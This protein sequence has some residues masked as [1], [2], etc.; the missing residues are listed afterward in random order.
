VNKVVEQFRKTE[1]KMVKMINSK[2]RNYDKKDNTG[3][4]KADKGILLK[5]KVMYCE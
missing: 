1:S 2:R 5:A 4:I 3:K